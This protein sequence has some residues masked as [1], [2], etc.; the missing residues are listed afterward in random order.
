M[1]LINRTKRGALTRNIIRKER[2]PKVTTTKIGI[3]M[4]SFDHPFLGASTLH[5]ADWIA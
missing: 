3:V 5:K 4:K 2:S 1:L